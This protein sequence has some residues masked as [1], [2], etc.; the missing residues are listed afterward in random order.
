LRDHP[1]NLALFNRGKCVAGQKPHIKSCR[2]A[3]YRKYTPAA[4]HICGSAGNGSHAAVFRPGESGDIVRS[5]F[6]VGMPATMRHYVAR[7]DPVG[8][9]LTAIAAALHAGLAE[10]NR[11]YAIWPDH[12]PLLAIRSTQIQMGSIG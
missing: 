12:E 9:T 4:Y 5:S 7:I 6:G 10:R 2:C 11:K 8:D 3:V 1:A